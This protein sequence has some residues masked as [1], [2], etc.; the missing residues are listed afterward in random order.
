MTQLRANAGFCASDQP[1]FWRRAARRLE[2]Q[3]ALKGST[4]AR[5]GICYGD[6]LN[7]WNEATENRSDFNGFRFNGDGADGHMNRLRRRTFTSYVSTYNKNP[8]PASGF[9]YLI[10]TRAGFA[11]S[12]TASPVSTSENATAVAEDFSETAS[13]LIGAQLTDALVTRRYIDEYTKVVYVDMTVYNP[14]ELMSTWVRLKFEETSAGGLVVTSDMQT[15]GPYGHENDTMLYVLRFI[16]GLGYLYYAIT[17]AAECFSD[18][19]RAYFSS[20]Q[21]WVQLLNL[22]MY[23]IQWICI[24]IA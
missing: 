2:Q 18:G 6:R 12:P 16:V 10:D 20:A 7:N 1:S 15:V 11:T 21:N 8:L 22:I 17:E 14:H 23:V 19:A 13:A 3:A 4:G 9:D 24:Y 5:A